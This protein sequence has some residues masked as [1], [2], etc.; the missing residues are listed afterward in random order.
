MCYMIGDMHMHYHRYTSK[1]WQAVSIKMLLSRSLLLA[2]S[3]SVCFT[4]KENFRWLWHGFEFDSSFPFSFPYRTSSSPL[5]Q[6]SFNH[7]FH[8][9]VVSWNW[10]TRKF[11]HK[12][13]VSTQHMN[14]RRH[15]W[16]RSYLTHRKF[17]WDYFSEFAAILFFFLFSKY[18]NWFELF[19]IPAMEFNA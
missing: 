10:K 2:R 13:K 11:H 17:S 9:T 19:P 6:C 14:W 3:V 8:F 15:G 18:L 7:P 4:W 1:V 16:C 12:I 5:N